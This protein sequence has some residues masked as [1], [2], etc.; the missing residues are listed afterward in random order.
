MRSRSR[1]SRFFNIVFD[2]YSVIEALSIHYI[3]HKFTFNFHLLDF[4]TTRW[5]I[6]QKRAVRTLFDIY[7]LIIDGFVE[8]KFKSYNTKEDTNMFRPCLFFPNAKRGEIV[9][10]YRPVKNIRHQYLKRK[11]MQK[12]HVLVLLCRNVCTTP[13]ELNRLALFPIHRQ[14]SYFIDRKCIKSEYFDCL[15]TTRNL[16]R[17]THILK[18]QTPHVHYHWCHIDLNV[19]SW[20]VKPDFSS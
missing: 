4:L 2:I 16:N 5:K 17:C 7:V 6:F 10:L 12:R 13:K 14:K 1:R 3:F 8:L 9:V 18:H 11:T 19:F 15:Q 20:F